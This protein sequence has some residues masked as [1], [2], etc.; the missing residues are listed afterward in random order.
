[1]LNVLITF[2][3]VRLGGAIFQRAIAASVILSKMAGVLA[4]QEMSKSSATAPA[5]LN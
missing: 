1:M 4:K 2:W 5:L 3:G